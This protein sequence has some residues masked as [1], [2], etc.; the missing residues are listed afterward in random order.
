M[1]NYFL[2]SLILALNVTGEVAKDR[3]FNRT[4][5]IK[6]A[7]DPDQPIFIVKI[8]WIYSIQTPDESLRPFNF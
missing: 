1:K 5:Q 4:S 6:L 7:P 2:A 3:K 8:L